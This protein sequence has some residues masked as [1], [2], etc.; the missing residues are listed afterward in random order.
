MNDLA[1]LASGTLQAGQLHYVPASA[2]SMAIVGSIPSKGA[3]FGPLFA[4]GD[5]ADIDFAVDHLPGDY[6]QTSPYTIQFASAGSIVASISS[7]PEPASIGMLGLGLA[8]IAADR[9]KRRF[10]VADRPI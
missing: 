2:T 5:L 4:P 10:V 9:R 6:T 1:M 3:N 7:V 8:T